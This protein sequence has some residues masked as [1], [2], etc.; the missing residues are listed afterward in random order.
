MTY[1]E[2]AKLDASKGYTTGFVSVP[3]VE[4]ILQTLAES[5]HY[6]RAEMHI[7]NLTEP[8][9]LIAL[10]K[11]YNVQDRCYFNVGRISFIEYIRESL[12]DNETLVSLTS[13]GE[14]LANAEIC[15]SLNIAYV[16]VAPRAITE[17]YVDRIHNYREENPVFIQTTPAQNEQDWELL[18][19]NG[20]DVIQTDYPEALF[21]F[22]ERKGFQITNRE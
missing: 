10:L 6:V 20:V 5:D 14:K 13:G 15:N 22:L 11:K 12:G 16:N 21:D 17:D 7:H 8:E 19:N 1:P 9:P 2:V 4:E 3:K 18:V